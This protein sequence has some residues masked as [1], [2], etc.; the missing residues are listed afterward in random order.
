MGG[1][2]PVQPWCTL[3]ANTDG[4]LL[5]FPLY[6]FHSVIF[7]SVGITVYKMNVLY[8]VQYVE[9]TVAPIVKYERREIYEV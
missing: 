8:I 1:G 7:N 2:Q 9:W 4:S 3:H 6:C 5:V